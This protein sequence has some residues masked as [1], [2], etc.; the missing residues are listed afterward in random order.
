MRT[1]Q[2]STT[3]ENETGTMKSIALRTATFLSLATLAVAVAASE[4][5]V[6]QWQPHDFDFRST[7]KPEN[8]FRAAFSATVTGPAGESFTTS[9]FYDGK[10]VWKLRIAASAAGDW[11]AVTHSD[12]ADLDGRTVRFTCT[13][14][15]NPKVHGGLRIDPRHRHHFVFDDGSRYCAVGYECDW[16]WAMDMNDP[17]LKTINPFLDKLAANGFNFIIL[18]A[19]A[20]DTS[21][22]KGRT[23][24]DDYG[25]AGLYP[26]AGSNAK[27]DHSRFNLDYWR[28]YDRVIAALS[29]RGIIAHV[30]I[31]VYNKMVKWPV[32]ESPE[33]D[34][35]F[36]WLVARYAAFPNVTWDFS[37]EAHYEKSLAYKIDRL[38]F[39]RKSDPYGRLL[40]AHTDQATYDRGE[41]DK[42]LDYRTDQVHSAWHAS[43]LAHC[44]MHEW[45]VL[46]SEFGYEY[47]PGG[48]SNVT[49]GVAQSPEE[50]CRRA[51]KI[52][53]AGGYGAYYYT[54]TAWD[55]VRPQDTP[56]GYAYFHHLREFF[57][58]TAYWLMLPADDLVSEGFC[59]ADPGREYVVYQDHAK[60]FSLKVAGDAAAEVPVAPSIDRE[61]GRW[62]DI[63]QWDG[64]IK[65]AAGLG[66]CAAG[67]ARRQSGGGN[68]GRTRQTDKYTNGAQID[69]FHAAAIL[70]RQPRIGPGGHDGNLVWSLRGSVRGYRLLGRRN[71]RRHRG[72]GH[73]KLGHGQFQLVVRHGRSGMEQ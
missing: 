63:A 21:W 59:L 69:A 43:I 64:E 28:H 8:P 58:Q 47:G 55:V 52:Y 61:M 13:K 51:W 1:G 57:E 10:G 24:P 34:Q 37:K 30:M 32:R 38:E 62:P 14:N 66:Q 54:Y 18:N 5:E 46:N 71:E 65:S 36:R 11:T 70:H 49:Y 23:G 7:S 15:T 20:Y 53:T 35:Y 67:V 39:V 2:D 33:D 48:R 3:C 68:S 4:T 50:V 56:P 31:K 40:T 72:R 9:G 73:G 17:A 29:D 44:A 45:P 19:Y 60:P 41:Y 27:P 16:L 6:Q 22:R 12:V 42:V 26:W 25:P